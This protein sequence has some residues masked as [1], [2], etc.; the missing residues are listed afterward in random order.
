MGQ[1]AAPSG[2]NPAAKAS[3]KAVDRRDVATYINT[4]ATTEKIAESKLYVQAS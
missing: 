2:L 4:V 1:P 3:T